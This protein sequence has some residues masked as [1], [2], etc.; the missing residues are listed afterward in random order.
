M[1]LDPTRRFSDRVADYVRYR[2]GYPEA[3]LRALV[4]ETGLGP[5]SRVADVGSGTGISTEL[6]LRSGCTVFAVEPNDAMRAAAEARL[7]SEP[8]FRSVAGTAEATGLPDAGADLVAAGQAFHWFDR[9]RFRTECRR[10]L[11]P[12]PGGGRVALFWNSRQTGPTPFL[13]DYE[14]LLRRFGTDYERVDHLRLGP[15]DFE[16]FFGGPYLS[17]RFPNRQ[18]FDFEGLRGR[19]LSSSYTPGP[20]HPD[21]APMLAELRR[22]FDRHQEGGRV[23]FEYDTEL[24]LGRVRVPADPTP[25]P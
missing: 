19:L 17:R 15:A 7:S 10:I 16:P 25:S 6:L 21:H 24:H 23:R 14:A 3:L 4:E 12:A 11:R 8:R 20:G 22:L 2:P 13:R 18:V 9:E 1:A 5:G